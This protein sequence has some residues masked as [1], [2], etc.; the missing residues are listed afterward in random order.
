MTNHKINK[1][2]KLKCIKIKNCC[3]VKDTD[4]RIKRQATNWEEIFAYPTKN[5]C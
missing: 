5:V 1:A 4:K 3:S 2:D